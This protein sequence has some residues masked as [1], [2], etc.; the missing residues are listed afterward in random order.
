MGTRRLIGLLRQGYGGLGRLALQGGVFP[1]RHGRAARRPPGI[2]RDN[3]LDLA[4]LSPV[5]G[6]Y[7]ANEIAI[8]WSWQGLV[9]VLE[10]RA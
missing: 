6:Y 10:T 3:D 2:N 1:C 5:Q 9:V 4:C 7:I 8:R